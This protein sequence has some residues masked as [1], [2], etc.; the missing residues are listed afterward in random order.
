MRQKETLFKLLHLK[1][2]KNFFKVY[3]AKMQMCGF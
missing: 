1:K 2:Q 3:Q